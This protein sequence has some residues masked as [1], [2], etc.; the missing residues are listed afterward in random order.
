MNFIKL[1]TMD[2]IPIKLIFFIWIILAFT[3]C[4]V[5]NTL[6]Y[7]FALMEISE[8]KN[9]MDYGELSFVD[10]LIDIS[11]TINKKE[12][13]FS[14]RNL[15]SNT[16][17]INWDETLYISEGNTGKVMHGGI[18]YIDRNMFQPP[19][20]I[21]KGT[22]HNDVIVPTDNVY[23]RDGMY[24]R[25]VSIAGKWEERE[26]FPHFVSVSEQENIISK[27]M[28]S[29][30]TIYMPIQVKGI[31]QE[32]N[33]NFKIINVADSKSYVPVKLTQPT[34]SNNEI[35]NYQQLI[36][37]E[38]GTTAD[39]DG[40]Q[41]PIFQIGRNIWMAGN[42]RVTRFN[43]GDQITEIIKDEKWSNTRKAAWSMYDN[44]L[45]YGKPLGYLYNG[46]AAL[47]ERN[48]CPSGW[49]IPTDSDW[50]NLIKTLGGPKEAGIK[51]RAT[52]GWLPTMN[53][54]NVSGLK[55][56]PSG[57][58]N[59][60]GQFYGAGKVGV[61]WS[62]TNEPSGVKLFTRT[63]SNDK[64]EVLKFAANPKIGAYVRCIRD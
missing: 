15:S 29:E 28:G 10:S 18:K 2:N 31:T 6:K 41:Y 20:V 24:G 60:N 54:T 25:T 7:D 45:K 30:F 35:A 47:N 53:G 11:F 1:R 27:L 23:W 57:S 37:N 16:L 38:V 5:F 49:H 4:G 33:F 63:L 42:L 48:I 8:T 58:R 34:K 36:I 14:L 32:Y 64:Q 12:I 46:N 17:K 9:S 19:S 40:N 13:S 43:N 3:N 55:L 22:V 52:K 21:P 51:L 26:L 56:L 61:W 50:E 39:I 62:S 44:S 59:E